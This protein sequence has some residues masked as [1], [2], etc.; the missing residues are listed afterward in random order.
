MER[1]KLLTIAVI[2]L[3][4]LNFLTIGFLLIRPDRP[5]RPMQSGPPRGEGP[6]QVIIER[7]AFDSLQKQQYL[8]LVAT[9]QQ[10]TRRLNEQSITLFQDYYKLVEADEPDSARASEL[11]D[12][13]G[14][15]QVG[16]ARL[17]FTHFQKIKALCRPD[18]QA[19]FKRLVSELSQLFGRQQ[20]PGQGRHTGP[21]GEGPPPPPSGMDGPPEGRPEGPPPQGAPQRP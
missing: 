21:P 13:I 6:A 17:N 12:Q 14:Q 18:Q 9:H 1:T 10:Q 7:L 5:N 15:N 20:R 3:L 19:S 2:G 11:S 4:L 16:Q 8:Q